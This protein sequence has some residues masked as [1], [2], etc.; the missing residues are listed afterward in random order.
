MNILITGSEG[1][2]GSKLVK[3]LLKYKHKII[4]LDLK[5]K[6]YISSKNVSFLKKNLLKKNDLLV[7]L[8]NKKIDLV[9]H[10]A[11]FLGV[12]KSELFELECL[13]TNIEGTKNLLEICKKLKIKKFIFSSSSEV[14][15][16]LYKRQMREEDPLSPV[17]AYGVSKM[18]CE[19][20]IKAYS[21]KSL[22]KYNIVR[23]FNVYGNHQKEDFVI[24]KFAKLISKNKMI[25]IFGNGKQVRSYCHVD[26][27]VNGLIKIIY[28]GKKN[29][30]YN[31]GNDLEPVN[32]NKLVK[33]FEKIIKRKVR[34]NFIPFEKSDRTFKR[35][36]FYRIPDIKKI[37]KDT[38]YK[39][40]IKL[41]EG[42]RNILKNEKNKRISEVF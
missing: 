9:I 23:F 11:A 36:I 10:L 33:Y 14:Y 3:E 20:Y 28:K 8:K 25:K 35:E 12:K 18:C 39:P 34:K 7:S 17:S 31:I 37:K 42:L 13:E 41:E 40:I 21:K 38:L 2:I 15:G 22:I 24:S 29:S 16:N 30:I 27:A 4:C 32:L 26:D 5:K 1:L 19:T 6:N